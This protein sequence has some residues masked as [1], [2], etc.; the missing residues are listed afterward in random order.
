MIDILKHFH[1]GCKFIFHD[2]YTVSYIYYHFPY[3][4]NDMEGEVK[5]TIDVHQVDDGINQE[6]EILKDDNISG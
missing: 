5:I 6:Q 1:I 4:F 2:F 3:R